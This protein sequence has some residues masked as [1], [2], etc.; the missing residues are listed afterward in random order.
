MA[1]L[2][3]TLHGILKTYP[4][5]EDNQVLTAAQLNGGVEYLNEQGRLT[6]IDHI[7]VGI[8][9]GLRVS[10]VD[11]DTKTV[12]IS[13]GLG[14]TTDGDHV[15]VP[16]DAWVFDRYKVY[17][18][19]T[20]TYA[21][22]MKRDPV[23]NTDVRIPAWELV[24]KTAE[25]KDTNIFALGEFDLRNQ[26]PKKFL[27]ADMVVVVLVESYTV[28]HDLCAALDCKNR[29]QEV[30]NEKRVL[31]VHRDD[32]G[33]LCKDK[34]IATLDKVAPLLPP[35]DATRPLMV[36]DI[37]DINVFVEKYK[38]ACSTIITPL[39]SALTS[40]SSHCQFFLSDMW[41]SDWG[42]RVTN[43]LKV[44]SGNH[45]IQ[46]FYDYLKDLV[47][48]YEAFRA[49]LFGDTSIC[50]ADLSSFPKHLVL[51]RVSPGE[52]VRTGF[53]PSRTVSASRE[54]RE[55]ARFLFAK[56]YA[57]LGCFKLPTDAKPAIRI[58][59][60]MGEDRNLEERAIP[61]Y[62]DPTKALHEK[63][64][65]ELSRQKRGARNCSYYADTY[66]GQSMPLKAQIGRFSFFRI[67]G[68]V[69]HG[70]D[71][72]IKEIENQIR[73]NNLPFSVR[74][75]RLGKA[76]TSGSS[77]SSGTVVVDRPHYKDWYQLHR[78]LRYELAK[79]FD[80]L[81]ESLAKPP[82]GCDPLGGQYARAAAATLRKP[83][84]EYVKDQQWQASAAIAI[85]DAPTAA[86]LELDGNVGSNLKSMANLASTESANLDIGL[87][88]PANALMIAMQMRMIA[89]LDYAIAQQKQTI[90]A[91]GTKPVDLTVFNL[92]R[93][94]HP[95]VEHLGGVCRAGTFVLVHNDA[96]NV[97]ADFMLPYPVVEPE[98]EVVIETEEPPIDDDSGGHPPFE[99]RPPPE[100]EVTLRPPFRKRFEQ[101]YEIWK[102]EFEE[103]TGGI[104][105][106][107]DRLNVDL[108]R[109]NV[110]VGHLREDMRAQV[111]H[112]RVPGERPAT[113][114]EA[115]QKENLRAIA[116][117]VE[118]ARTRVEVFREES[119]DAT[120]EEVQV[121]AEQLEQAQKD[122]VTTAIAATAEIAA[123]GIKV[124]RGTDG[125]AIMSVIAN[126][127]AG[128]T[129]QGA[130]INLQNGL[131]GLPG[132]VSVGIEMQQLVTNM[133][134]LTTKLK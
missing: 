51:G 94:K 7:G 69:G 34:D 11:K 36:G 80:R 99:I 57:M 106:D 18:E 5:F 62:Y 86:Q 41:P 37:S 88:I 39:K 27:L 70:A 40:I 31:L 48:T 72:A 29:G 19:G 112:V 124:T 98:V 110:E 97:V 82:P 108:D 107:V 67:E 33:S 28:D 119:L 43:A 1:Q 21:P 20:P 59:P 75:V 125:F 23:T 15:C 90:P 109:V 104:K 71:D 114:S 102:R 96:G 100:W 3:R 25:D 117:R 89:G 129:S 91:G 78:G 63:W 55:H 131:K 49:E 61:F 68:H 13:K 52:I 127:V 118:A 83:Y 10:F 103:R 113:T 126:S 12:H 50:V 2:K 87:S 53:Y 26:T 128:I 121:I 93:D 116:R 9:C 47:D 8:A 73:A 45:G 6:R 38:S 32:V 85:K 16:G 17:G 74:K 66:G 58:T 123:L 77:G 92:L 64:C 84:T 95:G 105:E 79:H 76:T 132:Q 111:G 14:I 35:V 24:R 101:Q 134:K 115:I 122:L 46:Y 30:R 56:L 120:G 130:I 4:V 133:A 65:F 81:A 44:P 54:Q 22:L 42:T 60:S